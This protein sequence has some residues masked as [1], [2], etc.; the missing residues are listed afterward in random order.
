MVTRTARPEPARR[1]PILTLL[2]SKLRPPAQQWAT[3]PRTGLV[4]RIH[5]AR[6]ARVILV[7]APAGYGKTTLLA[8]WVQRLRCPVGWHAID[9]TDN[10]PSIF[11]QYLACALGRAGVAVGEA[12]ELLASPVTPLAAVVAELGA[13]VESTSEPAVIVLDDVHLLENRLCVDVLGELCERVPTRSRLVLSTRTAQNLAVAYV[14]G[15]GAVLRLGAD[16]LRLSDVEAAALLRGAGIELDE[17]GVR[18]VN[19]RCEGWAAGLYLAA[20]AGTTAVVRLR[21]P[22]TVGV[23]RFLGDY[24][25]LEV[26]D[27]LDV[28]DRRFL[29]R[30]SVLGRVCGPLC[31]A[32]LEASGSEARLAALARANVFVEEI[33]G[34]GEWFRLHALMR[35][36]LRAELDDRDH[37]A[38]ASLLHRAADWYEAVGDIDAA[39]ECAVVTGDRERIARLFPVAALPAYWSG[40]SETLARWLASID[41]AQLLVDNPGAAVLG[42]GILA[43]L[44]RPEAAERWGRAVLGCDHDLRMPDGSPVAA[45]VA[46]LRALLCLDGAEAMR[47]DAETSLALLAEGSSM[48]SNVQCLL[49]FAHFLLGDDGSAA[50]WFETAADTAVS[51]GASVGASVSLA[52]GSLLALGREDVRRAGELAERSYEIAHEAHLDDYLTTTAVDVACARLA[53]AEGRRKAARGWAERVDRLL[54]QLTYALPW[55]AVFVRLELAH[56]ELALDNPA[57]ARALLEEI[58]RILV[59]RPSLGI[60][61]ERVA[62]LRDDLDS[63]RSVADGWSSELTPAELRLL[64]L[65]AG[66]LSFREIAERLEISRNTVKTQ[67]IAVYRKL[68]VTSRSEAVVRARELG[69]LSGDVMRSA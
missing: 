38:A 13:A 25:R 5:G 2:E 56:L 28:E 6:R 44:G 64:P 59:H 23:D 31:D 63:G 43:L 4:D 68:D 55:L 20:L 7:E 45:W 19:D 10:D 51:L 49:G 66:Y 30:V 24:F 8:N 58:D 11:L 15:R 27:P 17:D 60:A 42:S 16:D 41:D 12:L 18:A 50:A 48:A 9:E 57:R 53:L 32:M 65:L 33:D 1:E 61:G 62:R 39:I 47:D 26:L 52:A 22:S 21:Q 40:R 35:D 14:H 46:N 37:G 3:L 29:E 54:P 69:L 67:A 36:L 34:A